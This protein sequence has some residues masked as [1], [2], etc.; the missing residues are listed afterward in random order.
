MVKGLPVE[1]MEKLIL[2]NTVVD[3]EDLR[4]LGSR[5]AKTV[6]DWLAAHEVP[7]ERLF[8]LPVKL[9]ETEGKSEASRESRVALSL[10]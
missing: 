5:R 1:E 10:K 4:D 3:E 8:L 9:V 6:L 2:A 7:A